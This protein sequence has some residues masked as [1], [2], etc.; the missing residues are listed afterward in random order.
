MHQEPKEPGLFISLLPII[1]LVVMLVINVMI[2]KDDATYGPNQLALL[3]SGMVV[4]AIGAF[5]LKVPYKKMEDQVVYSISLAT[6]AC[7]IL[8]VVGSLIGIWIVSG[9]VP[10]MIYYG[11]KIINPTFFLPVACIS[12]C[13]VALST[14]SSWSTTGTVGLALIGIGNALGIPEGMIAGAIISGA[15][16]GDKMSPLSDTTNLAPAMAGTDLFTHIRHMMY[17]SIP[18]ILMAIIGFTILG[19]FYGGGILDTKILN[20]TLAVMES[21][22]NISL[23]LFLIP[24]ATIAMV[25]RQIPAFPALVIG[26]LLGAVAAVI[27][28]PELL[29]RMSDGVLTLKSA[30]QQLLKVAFGG[31]TIE[32]GNATID[33]LF[34]RGG[35]VNMLNTVWLIMMAM[36][37][38]GTLEATGML[39]KLANTVLK[40]VVGTGS[41]VGSTLAT[42]LFM[43]MTASDQYLA[44]VVPGRMFKKAYDDYG[45]HPKNLSRALEDSGTVTSVLVPWNSGGAYNSGVLGVATLTYLP[46]CFFNILSPLVSLFLATT[47]WTIEKLVTENQEEE[48]AA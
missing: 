46:F 10:T 8:L 31:F 1:F 6:Q 17:T 13:I 2:F 19:L 15:Y 11:L 37:F 40:M 42:C 45:L 30:Y 18:A 48:S 27:F 20:E 41:L 29:T 33:K 14:G 7:L 36:V 21:N 44:I 4:L 34:C 35:M 43:N 9:I 16:F 24:V 32:S 38:G 26:A 47:G 5:H 3:L 22:F 23:W 12:C 39:A 25:A 28:Q